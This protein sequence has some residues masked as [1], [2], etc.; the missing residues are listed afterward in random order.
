MKLLTI[1]TLFVS[2][3]VTVLGADVYPPSLTAPNTFTG[4][5]NNFTGHLQQNG[6]DVV[7]NPVSGGSDTYWGTN[8]ADGT[9]T[10]NSANG[11][12]IP[13]ALY[14]TGSTNISKFFGTVH[15]TDG[16]SEGITLIQGYYRGNGMYLSNVVA[17]SGWPTNW[18]YTVISNSPWVTT[19]QLT[20]ST[21][22]TT[23]NSQGLALVAQVQGSTNTSTLSSMG[24]A[25][26]SGT[27]S[28][29]VTAT[30]ATSLAGEGTIAMTNAANQTGLTFALGVL[31][32]WATNVVVGSFTNANGGLGAS[33]L[34]IISKASFGT[35]AGVFI[36]NSGNQTNS[37]NLSAGYVYS[38]N[39][40][41]TY[42]LNETGAHLY[43]GNNSY[44]INVAG[45]TFTFFN[46]NDSA[47]QS[48]KALNGT[49]SG[50]G[51][52]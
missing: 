5:T 6:V 3:S 17:L 29:A 15:V 37:G 43:M 18:P 42:I 19:N 30:T 21:N 51:T 10:N 20:G 38:V 39:G 13:G 1:L 7:T 48:I 22:T 14:V 2:A 50:T 46:G 49:F 36:D 24:V 33:N 27:V 4:S 16:N 52:F 35:N 9:V 41:T 47:L 23:L 25:L 11:V 12:E 40:I 44:D 34:T 28:N 45:N 26:Y 31:K 8:S 32:F